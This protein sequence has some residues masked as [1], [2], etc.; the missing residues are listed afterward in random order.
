MDG[1]TFCQRVAVDGTNGGHGLVYSESGTKLKG[2]PASFRAHR[3]RLEGVLRESL[4]TKW[5]HVLQD[6]SSSGAEHVLSFKE[7]EKV[8]S[9]S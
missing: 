7:E 9:S 1:S 5:T 3:G 6:I 2:L 4:D 8:Q